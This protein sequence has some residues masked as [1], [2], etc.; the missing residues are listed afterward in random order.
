LPSGAPTTLT[1]TYAPT[2]PATNQINGPVNTPVT[3]QGGD[4]QS[5]VL[6][7]ASTTA[8][9]LPALPVTFACADT[10]AAPVF[11][12][13]TTLNLKFTPTSAPEPD[14]IALAAT[15]PSTPGICV[16]DYTNNNPGAFAVARLNNGATGQVTVTPVTGS[17]GLP[18]SS[19]QVCE[20]NPSNAQCLA[21]PANSLTL[22]VNAQ[23]TPTF[24]VFI[25]TNDAIGFAPGA[26]RVGLNFTDPTT[27]ALLGSTDVALEAQ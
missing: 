20:T 14:M 11:P 22:T 6:A 8:V 17:V 25:T 16:A 13:L 27:G 1:L 19:L 9:N 3:I 24:S 15:N 26:A 10:Q 4:T 5:F 23:A 12:G 21:G 18:L 2:N 7:F